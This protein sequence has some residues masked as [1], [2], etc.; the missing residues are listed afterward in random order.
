M[1]NLYICFAIFP[2]QFLLIYSIV[3][4]LALPVFLHLVVYI[5]GIVW[6]NDG[7]VNTQVYPSGQVDPTGI[8]HRSL[9]NY[10]FIMGLLFNILGYAPRG[11]LGVIDFRLRQSVALYAILEILPS[12]FLLIDLIFLYKLNKETRK[13]MRSKCGC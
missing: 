4:L 1:S 2:N 5:I 8:D 12:M 11:L 7:I 6:K 10:V 3:F 9:L 13:H